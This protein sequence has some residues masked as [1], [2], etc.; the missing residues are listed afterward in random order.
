MTFGDGGSFRLGLAPPSVTGSAPPE[1]AWTCGV[2]LQEKLN[3]WEFR[4]PIHLN[5]LDEG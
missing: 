1:W 2:G 4:L 3:I 5:Q